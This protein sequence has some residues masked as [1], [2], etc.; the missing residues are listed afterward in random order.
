MDFILV[1]SEFLVGILLCS[2]LDKANIFERCPLVAEV[3]KFKIQDKFKKIFE[4]RM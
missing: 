1:W 3:K 2:E 4:E